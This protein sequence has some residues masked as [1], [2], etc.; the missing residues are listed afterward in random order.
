MEGK[1]LGKAAVVFAVLGVVGSG[2][3]M[4]TDRNRPLD[5][6]SGYSRQP[7]SDAPPWKPPPEFVRTDPAGQ[8][9]AP[10]EGT[11]QRK[12]ADSQAVNQPA[13]WQPLD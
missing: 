3:S 11:T 12:Q 1:L 7:D 10:A 5:E 13:S 2:C 8:D 4:F 9:A 6:Y